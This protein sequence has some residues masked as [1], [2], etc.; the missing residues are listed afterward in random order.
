MEL[1][2]RTARAIIAPGGSQ[3]HGIDFSTVSDLGIAQHVAPTGGR[4]LHPETDEAQTRLD[5]DR[6]GNP[7][8]RRHEHIR[9]P[10]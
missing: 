1:I 10:K 7:E 2:E 4:R 8:G 5:Q 3:S 6:V 9:G